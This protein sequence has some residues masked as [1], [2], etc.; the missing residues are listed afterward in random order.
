MH[1]DFVL[2]GYHPNA[3]NALKYNA[4][5]YVGVRELAITDKRLKFFVRVIG[6]VNH[7]LRHFKRNFFDILQV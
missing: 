5:V 6:P 3:V 4:K 1:N 7:C 2:Q